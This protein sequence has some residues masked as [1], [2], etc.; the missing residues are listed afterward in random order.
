[1]R[2]GEKREKTRATGARLGYGFQHLGGV[3]RAKAQRRRRRK[4]YE[5]DSTAA[6]YGVAQV[7]IKSARIY[8]SGK[9]YQ[10]VEDPGRRGRAARLTARLVS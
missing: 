6:A 3:G 10:V 4:L 9:K 7:R 2:G 8:R 5:F 1:M